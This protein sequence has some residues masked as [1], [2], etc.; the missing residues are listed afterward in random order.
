[1]IETLSGQ[2]LI[3]AG[4]LQGKWFRDAL[5]AGNA[6]L[7]SGGSREAALAAALEY[8]PA[9]TLP[10][11]G[12][13]DID[14]HVNIRAENAAELANVESVRATMRELARTPVVRAAAIMPDAC[15]S[16]PIGT[17]PVGGVVASEAIHPGMHSADICCSMAISVLPGVSPR[18][19]LDAVHAVTHFGPGGRPRGAQIK[20]S[21]ATL[22]AFDGNHYLNQI[23]SAA[24]EHFA[25]QGDGNH[26][27]YVGQ[28]KS[29]GETALVTHHGSRGP[30]ARLYE[31]GMRVA[32]RFREMLSPGTL[33]HN[34][35]IPAESEEGE[36]YWDALQ[37]VRQWTK[38]NHFAIHDMAVAKLGAR[39]ADRFWNE[40]NFVFRKSDGLFYHGKGATPA[41]DG[42]APDATDLTIIPLNMAEA[43]L[44]VR[45][46]NAAHGL[47]FSPHGAGR[48]FSR[49]AHLRQLAVEYG[50]DSRGLSPNNIADIMAKETAGLDVRFFSGIPDVSELPGA[51]KNAAQVKAQIGEYGL[52][53]IVDEVI[54][55][56]SIMAGDWQKNAPWRN[57]KKKRAQNAQ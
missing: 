52:A 35:W 50:A 53:E 43:I 10:L 44:I 14:I 7:R 37:I 11:K 2:D 47:G 15:P 6:V 28:M 41:F 8:Q 42:W 48:N 31:R 1:M 45:G 20:P 3:D 40:H 32:N 51:Y 30:G 38:E 21:E 4:L 12:A 16:G 49:S 25:T 26:F 9:P 22:A 46:S 23:T 54:P 27:A 17:I 33:T 56:G 18:D 13:G 39:V 5:D 29:S 19:L 57:K 34:A 24:I 55:Y 36:T